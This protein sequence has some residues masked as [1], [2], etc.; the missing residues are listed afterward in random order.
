MQKAPSSEFDTISLSSM[1]EILSTATGIAK[2]SLIFPF[3][4]LLVFSMGD[5]HSAIIFGVIGLIGV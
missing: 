4:G 1:K 5:F 2:T 3:L